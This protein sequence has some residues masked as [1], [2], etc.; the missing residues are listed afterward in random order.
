LNYDLPAIGAALRLKVLGTV[1]GQN[2]GL[3]QSVTVGFAK[4]LY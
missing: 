1:H 2:T 4:K 3:S